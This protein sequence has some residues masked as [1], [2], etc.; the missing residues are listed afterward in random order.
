LS[1]GSGSGFFLDALFDVHVFE[2]TGL[3]D[4]AAVFALDEFGVFVAADDL[5]TRML[6]RLRFTDVLRRRGRLGSHKSGSVQK[7][8]KD[9]FAGNFSSF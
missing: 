5:H 4:L 2:F 7:R 8:A 6:A 3:E 1:R 9:R